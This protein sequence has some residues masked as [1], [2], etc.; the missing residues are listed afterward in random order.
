MPWKGWAI[1]SGISL[2]HTHTHT[3]TQRNKLNHDS[4]KNFTKSLHL[5]VIAQR[6]LVG[7]RCF[8]TAY[9]SRL[10][11]S[12]CRFFFDFFILQ[13]EKNRLSQNDGKKPRYER[14]KMN[15]NFNYNK[16]KAFNFPYVEITLW[17]IWCS[18]WDFHKR[19]LQFQASRIIYVQRG[20]K[21]VRVVTI[22][23]LNRGFRR[24]P[25]G[26]LNSTQP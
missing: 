12:R 25:K 26:L 17:C 4:P 23:H 15:E 24:S 22:S 5:P 9:R 13:D 3:T 1:I 21:S 14:N 20:Y 10:L 18:W 7:Y 11:S 6:T 8:D 2:S 19:L 16:T